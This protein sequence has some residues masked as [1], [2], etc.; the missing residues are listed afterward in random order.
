MANCGTPSFY[1]R[2]PYLIQLDIYERTNRN[3]S[4]IIGTFRAVEDTR[5]KVLL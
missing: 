4:L 5:Q 3:Y 2:I 1:I